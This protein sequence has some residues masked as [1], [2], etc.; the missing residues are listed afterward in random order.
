MTRRTDARC[1]AALLAALAALLSGCADP[2]KAPVRV[3]R[4][5]VVVLPEEGGK[6][7]TVV[8][9]AGKDSIVLDRAYASARLSGVEGWQAV[10]SDEGEVQ[11]MFSAVKEALPPKPISFML[12]FIE[13]KDDFTPDSKQVV[14]KLF[15]EIAG[16]PAPEIT[17]IG[18]T[19]SIGSESYNDMLS[20][21]RAQKVRTMLIDLGIAPDS[22]DATGRG[23]REL[24]IQTR[25]S[26][27]A[28]RR[29]EVSVR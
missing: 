29:V 24:L 22:I 27:L 8:M 10:T 15:R 5:M 9:Y 12:N 7:G 28:N 14:E 20:L 11:Q 19:D 26:E 4:E 16:R 23:K 21:Q 18:H 13:G 25:Q 3:H 2:P 17:V 6:V 1:L